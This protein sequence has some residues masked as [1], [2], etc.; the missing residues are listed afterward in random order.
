M[1]MRAPLLCLLAAAIMSSCHKGD[2][3]SGTLIDVSQQWKIDALGNLI[4]GI[5]DDQWHLKTFSAQE[6]SLFNSL[7]TTDLTGTVKP[8]AVID[9]AG[10]H[11]FPNPFSGAHLM[12]FLFSTSYTGDVVLKLVYVDKSM[13]PLFKTS[14]RLHAT[15]L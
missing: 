9:T 7:D 15:G 5:V 8:D 13:N 12:V 6:M 3:N 1:A 10:Y 2:S 14:V 4:P 11:F